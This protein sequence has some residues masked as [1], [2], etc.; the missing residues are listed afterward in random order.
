MKL[1]QTVA[2]SPV[3]GRRRLRGGIPDGRTEAAALRSPRRPDGGCCGAA[4]PAFGRRLL[5]CGVL[6]GC[7]GASPAYFGGILGWW[8][9]RCTVTTS[10]RRPGDS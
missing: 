3:V 10:L 6:G 7:T 2:A 1:N 9:P 5:R 8:R 4:P